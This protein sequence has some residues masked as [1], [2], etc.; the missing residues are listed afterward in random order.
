MTFK[1]GDIVKLDLSPTLGHEQSGD[2][3]VIVNTIKLIS[4]TNG[5]G[6]K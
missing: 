1:Q 4:P 5:A 6:Q 3:P 2:R